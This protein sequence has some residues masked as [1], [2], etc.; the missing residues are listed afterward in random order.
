MSKFLRWQAVDA[1]FYFCDSYGGAF[2]EIEL[3]RASRSLHRARTQRHPT[4][5]PVRRFDA[6]S[7]LRV[8]VNETSGAAAETWIGPGPR[9]SDQPMR[10]SISAW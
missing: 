1:E 7:K 8:D 3:V 6:V 9:F 5:V 2:R 10:S 4:I